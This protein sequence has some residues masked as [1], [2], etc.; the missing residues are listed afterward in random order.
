MVL[1]LGETEGDAEKLILEMKGGRMTKNDDG[2]GM[3]CDYVM[4]LLVHA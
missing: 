2:L 3:G 4:L 1:I